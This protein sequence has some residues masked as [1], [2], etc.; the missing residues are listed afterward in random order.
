MTL[1]WRKDGVATA[2]VAA[3]A[4]LYWAYEAEAAVPGFGGERMLS[5]AILVLGVAACAAG[6]GAPET[7]A[8]WQAF[9]GVIGFA[10]FGLAFAGMLAGTVLL[11]RLTLAVV[12]AAWVATT[13]RRAFATPAPSPVPDDARELVS[14]W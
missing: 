2:L 4:G 12:V 11:V 14:T 3:A 6:G 10:A 8:R 1:S 7:S 13:I 9:L 5:A